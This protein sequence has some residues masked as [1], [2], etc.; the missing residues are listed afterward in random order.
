MFEG[1]LQLSQ[2]VLDFFCSDG[3]L[4]CAMAVY[5]MLLLPSQ[6]LVLEDNCLEFCDYIFGLLLKFAKVY[7][8]TIPNW[9]II[10]DALLF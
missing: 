9:K 2:A 10:I 1:F 3:S 7:K 8:I 5:I 4:T 6:I